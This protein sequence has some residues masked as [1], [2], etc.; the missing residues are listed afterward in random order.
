MEFLKKRFKVELDAV[1]SGSYRLYDSYDT[2]VG[3]E[4]EDNQK[5]R[6]NQNIIDVYK[7]V[8]KREFKPYEK[9]IEILAFCS[10]EGADDDLMTDDIDLP[11]VFVEI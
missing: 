10:P 7:N 5:D 4:A 3:S 9:Y 11:S 1:Y 8:M 2:K 6:E